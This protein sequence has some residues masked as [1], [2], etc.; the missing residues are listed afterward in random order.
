MSGLDSKLVVEVGSQFECLCLVPMSRS[1][2]SIGC[3]SWDQDWLL[4]QVSK[5]DTKS[6]KSQF[7]FISQFGCRVLSQSSKSGHYASIEFNIESQLLVPMLS[8]ILYWPS[9]S[10]PN[11]SVAISYSIN[12]EFKF[13]CCALS[14]LWCPNSSVKP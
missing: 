12:I 11:S 4:D 10:S 6:V 1:S 9:R 3:R 5:S 14:R 7:K 13:E 2:V 8:W